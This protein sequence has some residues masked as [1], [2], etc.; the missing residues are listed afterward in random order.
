MVFSILLNVRKVLFGLTMLGLILWHSDWLASYINTLNW[1]IPVVAALAVV[2]EVLFTLYLMFYFEKV[3]AEVVP[4]ADTQ[5][6]N[7]TVK[8][9]DLRFEFQGAAYTLPHSDSVFG[10]SI[11]ERQTCQILVHKRPPRLA[12]IDSFAQRYMYLVISLFLFWSVYSSITNP[13]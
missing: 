4:G 9:Y 2:N 5:Q 1:L 7:V 6:H 3:Q 8:N 13:L 10:R 12:F 11:N